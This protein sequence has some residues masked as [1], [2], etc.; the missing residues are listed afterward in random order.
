[1]SGYRKLCTACFNDLSAKEEN[2]QNKLKDGTTFTLNKTEYKRAKSAIVKKDKAT[3]R[4]ASESPFNPD[5]LELLRGAMNAT[6]HVASNGNVGDKYIPGSAGPK[7]TK[8]AK[9]MDKFIEGWAQSFEQWVIG[10]H[11]QANV[12]TSTLGT[13]VQ[14]HDRKITKTNTTKAITTDDNSGKSLEDW[15]VGMTIDD[16]KYA[17]RNSDSGFTC[18]VLCSGGCVCTLASIRAGFKMIWGTEICPDHQSHVTEQVK[19]LKCSCNG[20]TQQHMWEDP[21]GA[22]CLGNTF[23][24]LEKYNTVDEPDYMTSGQPCPNYSLSGSKKVED[25]ET[26][27][28]FVQQNKNH[29]QDATENFQAGNGGQCNQRERWK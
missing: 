15:R 11:P 10:R 21:T 5:Q 26:G 12:T 28:M 2:A 1:M 13:G 17:C 16:A 3:K 8:K 18:A 27:W 9:A 22:P 23:T 7:S 19:D 20:N 6:A 14:D 4:K 25:G 24:N 29:N